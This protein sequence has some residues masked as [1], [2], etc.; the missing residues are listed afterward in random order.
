MVIL[1]NL[2]RCIIPLLVE[3]KQL[4]KLSKMLISLFFAELEHKDGSN[5]TILLNRFCGIF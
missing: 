5:L 4:F 3:H 1:L 2:K